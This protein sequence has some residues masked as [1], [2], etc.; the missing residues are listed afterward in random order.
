M[1]GRTAL[2]GSIGAAH[3]EAMRAL[4]AYGSKRGGTAELVAHG[5]AATMAGDW[6]DPAAIDRWAAGIVG[7][8]AAPAA[9][10]RRREA[11]Q[12]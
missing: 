9:F 4:V 12:N 11:A 1:W 3:A 7:Q 6:R 10:G 5:L 2:P 8:L